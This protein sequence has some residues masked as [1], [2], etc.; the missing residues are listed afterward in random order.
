MESL[1]I[2]VLKKNT[3]YYLEYYSKGSDKSK[4]LCKFIETIPLQSL[5]FSHLQHISNNKIQTVHFTN[6]T[7]VNI[8][9][10]T[11]FGEDSITL[12]YFNNKLYSYN[13]F[14]LIYYILSNWNSSIEQYR[15]HECFLYK[16]MSEEIIL[17]KILNIPYF[18]WNT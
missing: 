13:E 18:T 8:N 16:P 3:Y 1:N 15:I 2:T 10:K 12:Y 5:E 6:V 14:K 17:K 9:I 4:I 7:N 11:S